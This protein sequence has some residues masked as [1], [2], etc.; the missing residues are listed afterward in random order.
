MR[1]LICVFGLLM[2]FLCIDNLQAQRY[3]GFSGNTDTYME[4][5][6]EMVFSDVN[7]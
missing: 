1:K 5:L 7:I 4:E 6:G 2:C 3:K